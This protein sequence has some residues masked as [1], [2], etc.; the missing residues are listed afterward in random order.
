[1]N[2]FNRSER[3]SNYNRKLGNKKKFINHKSKQSEDP[4]QASGVRK[5]P[6]P[7]SRD[8][9]KGGIILYT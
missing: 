1:M 5:G 8:P 2:F 4:D 9:P 3:I 7:A 6:P